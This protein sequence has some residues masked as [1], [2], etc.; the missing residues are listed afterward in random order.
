MTKSNLTMKIW[1]VKKA[2]P[3]LKKRTKGFKFKYVNLTEIEKRL[4]PLMQEKKIAYSHRLEV[5]NGANTLTTTIFNQEDV[6]DKEIHSMIIPV[7]V[8]LKGMNEYQSLGSAL[9]YFRRYHLV[10][11][12]GIIADDDVD[13]QNPSEEKPNDID[14]IAK[15]KKLIQLGRK[16]PTLEKYL[17]GIESKITK[18]TRDEII[19]LILENG[20]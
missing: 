18:E 19:K 6:N 12:F 5:V 11:A 1:E 3:T 15:V 16:K 20:N 14:H 4:K 7:G 9:T 2:L 17:S 13:A 10:V 8:Q